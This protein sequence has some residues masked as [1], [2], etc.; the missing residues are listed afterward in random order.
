MSTELA[1]QSGQLL[2]LLQQEGEPIGARR[3]AVFVV[4]AATA[5]VRARAGKGVATAAGVLA[6]IGLVERAAFA[7]ASRVEPVMYQGAPVGDPAIDVQQPRIEWREEGGEFGDRLHRFGRLRLH[8]ARRGAQDHRGG[9]EDHPR[10][11][12]RFGRLTPHQ[13]VAP[14]Q[15]GLEVVQQHRPVLRHGV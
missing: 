5:A 6:P 9:V 13:G 4:A 1:D 14:L 8:A 15:Q 2:G 7:Q 10:L 12:E 3:Q 11:L